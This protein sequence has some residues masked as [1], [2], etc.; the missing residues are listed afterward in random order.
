MQRPFYNNIFA[1][2][3][4][5]RS[6]FYRC[7]RKATNTCLVVVKPESL[8]ESDILNK[9]LATR[10]KP[11]VNLQLLTPSAQTAADRQETQPLSVFTQESKEFMKC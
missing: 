3:C 4:V 9:K 7:L 5:T 10:A 8:S 1:N 11:C 6:F 2:K